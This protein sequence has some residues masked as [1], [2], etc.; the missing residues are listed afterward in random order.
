MLSSNDSLLSANQCS[1][2]ASIYKGKTLQLKKVVL[3]TSL[4]EWRNYNQKFI[5]CWLEIAIFQ[6]KGLSFHLSFLPQHLKLPTKSGKVIPCPLFSSFWFCR[7]DRDSD[8]T[9]TYLCLDWFVWKRMIHQQREQFPNCQ[10]QPKLPSC[11]DR[12]TNTATTRPKY[13]VC[14]PLAAL[15]LLPTH[16]NKI[17]RFLWFQWFQDLPNVAT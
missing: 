7:I 2:F 5:V 6:Y 8:L 9:G 17:S 12:S 11:Y 14:P 3:F 1:N 13:L 16:E 15:V 10:L 4:N